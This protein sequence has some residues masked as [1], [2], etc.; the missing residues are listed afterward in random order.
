MRRT[1]TVRGGGFDP[2]LN[3]YKRTVCASTFGSGMLILTFSG[4]YFLTK[5]KIISVLKNEYAPIPYFGPTKRTVLLYGI[6]AI[7][8]WSD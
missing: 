6:A 8:V 2:P 1:F 3:L 7:L 4:L 5:K